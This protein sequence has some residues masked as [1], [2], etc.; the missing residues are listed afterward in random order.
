M[1]PG[2]KWRR[3]LGSA[4]D[5]SGGPRAPGTVSGDDADAGSGSEAEAP[6]PG[7]PDQA[8]TASVPKKEGP[9]PYAS[10]LPPPTIPKTVSL[11]AKPA[12]PNVQHASGKSFAP[13]PFLQLPPKTRARILA[14]SA[15]PWCV[16]DFKEELAT[17][18]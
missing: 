2:S 13:G 9:G 11:P 4:S 18:M 6:S 8:T 14:N 7:K 12:N 15:V 5:L 3:G 16:G 17:A 10:T 1:R